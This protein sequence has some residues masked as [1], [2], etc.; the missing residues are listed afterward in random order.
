MRSSLFIHLMYVHIYI[1][2]HNIQNVQIAYAFYF[3]KKFGKDLSCLGEIRLF[4]LILPVSPIIS[5]IVML[6]DQGGFMS[7]WLESS[8]L[9]SWGKFKTKSQDVDPLLNWVESKWERH[10]GFV[11]EAVMEGKYTFFICTAYVRY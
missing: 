8:G 11:I 2:S 7:D 3:V 9:T 5:I 1:V 4:L 6:D 10:A